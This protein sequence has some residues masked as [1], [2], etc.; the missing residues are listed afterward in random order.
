M[1]NGARALICGTLAAAVETYSTNKGKRYGIATLAIASQATTKKTQFLSV[2]I[3]NNK[4]LSTSTTLKK[5]MQLW[6]IGDLEST[7]DHKLTTINL[8][9]ATGITVLTKKPSHTSKK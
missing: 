2:Y 6:I 8:Y 9:E 1:Y 4:L 3:W 7:K 5:G